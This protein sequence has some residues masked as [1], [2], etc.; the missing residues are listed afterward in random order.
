[1]VG[2]RVMADG[3]SERLGRWFGGFGE[4]QGSLGEDCEPMIFCN[5]LMYC[6]DELGKSTVSGL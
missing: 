3:E 1:M 5:R 4:R 2:V 6:V